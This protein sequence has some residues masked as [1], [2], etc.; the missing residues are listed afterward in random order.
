[1]LRFFK[2]KPPPLTREQS[3][4]AIPV[5][6]AALRFERDENGLYTIRVPLRD[7]WWVKG[8]SKV[9]PLPDEGKRIS[10]DEMGSAVLDLCDG[11]TTVKEMIAETAKRFKLSRKE[12]EISLLAFLRELGKKGIIG[13]A[14]PKKGEEA[15]EADEKTQEDSEES[16]DDKEQEGESA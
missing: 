5:R 1:M 2:R 3:L 10:L 12:A 4:E 7:A 11:E 9:F 14:V 15:P 16:T 13:L 8:L 6:N